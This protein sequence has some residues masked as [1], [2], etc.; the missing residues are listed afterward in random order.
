MAF[1]LFRKKMKSYYKKIYNY[2]FCC[3][4]KK[5]SIPNN[6]LCPN[7]TEYLLSYAD[8]NSSISEFDYNKIYVDSVKIDIF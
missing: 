6:E 3:L 5:S 2:L 8:E 4:T 1:W 7:C